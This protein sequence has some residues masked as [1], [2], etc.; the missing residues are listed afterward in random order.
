[1]VTARSLSPGAQVQRSVGAVHLASLFIDEGFGTLDRDTLVLIAETLQGLQVG[2]RMVGIITH[3][4]ELRDEFAQ[5]VIV[6]KRQGYSTVRVRG[7]EEE[8]WPVPV[9]VGPAP[10]TRTGHGS[11]IK[12]A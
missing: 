1:M 4:P 8:T 3:I 10:A 2:G 12:T 7:M 11:R 5:Q 9:E 6:T